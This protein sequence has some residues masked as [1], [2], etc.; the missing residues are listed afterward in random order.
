MWHAVAVALG[1]MVI[2][3]L[4]AAA[5]QALDGWSVVETEHFRF[6]FPPRPRVSP[7]TFAA[8]EEQAFSRLRATFTESLPGKIDFYVWNTSGGSNE[9]S[10]RRGPQRHTS[11]GCAS[12]DEAAG[13]MGATAGE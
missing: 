6:H 11:G 1:L 10:R 2:L 13:V 5:G 12:P 8:A 4:P 9:V 3:P 7:E